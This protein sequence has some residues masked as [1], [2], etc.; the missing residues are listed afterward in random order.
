MAFATANAQ[1]WQEIK[2]Y[3]GKFRVLCISDMVQKVDSIDTEVGKLAYHTYFHQPTDPKSAENL[4]YMV[5]YVDYPEFT[6]HSD[7]S[8]LL[9]SFFETTIESAVEAVDGNL[10]YST[11]T[12]LDGFPGKLWRI[13]YLEGKVVIKTRG[14]VVKNRYYNIQ[15]I[16]F[17]EKSINLAAERFFD[18]FY[19]FDEHVTPSGQ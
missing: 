11:D 1:N 4:F 3:E 6:V 18:S 8:A 9:E 5:S 7:S 17:K 15:T 2:S 13:E 10:L 14:F 12:N 16:A 19:L